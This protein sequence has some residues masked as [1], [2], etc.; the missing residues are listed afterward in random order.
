MHVQLVGAGPRAR[1]RTW[2]QP[3]LAEGQVAQ[4]VAGGQ[5]GAQL[6][7]G[8]RRGVGGQRRGP[9]PAGP[10][11]R[12]PSGE[13]WKHLRLRQARREVSL[14]PVERGG[15]APICPPRG[16]RESGFPFRLVNSGVEFSMHCAKN[17]VESPPRGMRF[18]RTTSAINFGSNFFLEIWEFF[19]KLRKPLRGSHLGPTSAPDPRGGGARTHPPPRSTT[20]YKKNLA[21]NGL[22]GV[23][24]AGT[25][26]H[27]LPQR[28]G[29]N[30]RCVPQ[31]RRRERGAGARQLQVEAVPRPLQLRRRCPATPPP[32]A[33]RK[34]PEKINNIYINMYVVY[35]YMYI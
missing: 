22:P 23:S 19:E 24:T 27:W 10:P 25:H 34:R 6:G 7:G 1:G 20:L 21:S 12:D 35:V 26:W 18:R 32:T 29:P 3:G 31:R 8:V 2:V 4:A 15:V 16:D 13:S 33:K 9:G 11:L 17:G 30:P 5:A 14:G 28:Q